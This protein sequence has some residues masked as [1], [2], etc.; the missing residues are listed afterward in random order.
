MQLGSGNLSKQAVVSIEVARLVLEYLKVLVWPAVGVWVAI[1]YRKHLDRLF[2][3]ITSETEEVEAKFLGLSA[4]FRKQI[5]Q[6]AAAAS[7]TAAGQDETSG[8]HVATL[9]LEQVRLL[10]DVFFS[11][12]LQERQAAAREVQQLSPLV[13]LD[14]ILKLIDSSLPGERVA[15]GIA[16]REQLLAN[17]A[18]A[19]DQNV[20]AAITRGL[21]DPLSRVRFR[22]VRAAAASPSL[23]ATL[24]VPL[25]N[26]ARE[27]SDAAV[28]E[29]AVRSLQTG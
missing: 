4:K 21:A 6:I 5:T 10:A 23:L 18:L 28:R 22:F 16:L 27:D 20:T 29:E 12:P 1:R 11:K 19:K 17:V 26:L 15:A 24:R 14:A 8:T 3:R 9:A 2:E 25:E 13:P 7:G